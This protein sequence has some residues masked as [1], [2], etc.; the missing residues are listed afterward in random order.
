MTARCRVNYK[1]VDKL[2]LFH[3]FSIVHFTCL[4]HDLNNSVVILMDHQ[5]KKMGNEFKMNDILSECVFVN[6]LLKLTSTSAQCKSGHFLAFI[7]N[8]FPNHIDEVSQ[9]LHTLI[10]SKGQRKLNL[11]VNCEAVLELLDFISQL[12]TSKYETSD[13]F[14][15]KTQQKLYLL[16]NNH[17][18]RHEL[19]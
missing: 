1:I 16:C 19:I 18:I 7:E 10:C 17:R 2:K 5:M 3:N 13:L 6:M 4:R 14:S 11:L 15:K 9:H 8:K 12:I